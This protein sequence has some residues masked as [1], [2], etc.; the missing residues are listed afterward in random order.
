MAKKNPI[1]TAI[2][3]FSWFFLIIV[4]YYVIHK[5]INPQIAQ[6]FVLHIWR[7]ILCA[8]I[9]LIAGG[10]GVKINKFEK[11]DPP[12]KV[13][14]QA[15]LGLGVLS[16]TI[17]LIGS[18]WKINLIIASV[19]ILIFSIITYRQIINWIKDFVYSKQNIF[20][21]QNSSTRIIIAL[22]IVI[23][24]SQLLVSLTPAT[25]Y[26]ALNYHLSLPKTYLLQEKISDIPWLIMSGMPQI[27]EMIYTALLALGGESAVLVFN[28]FTG[29]LILSG[30]VGFLKKRTDNASAWVGAASLFGGY[31]F[32]SALS[33]GYVD[34]MTAFFGLG[35][36]VLVDEFILSGK[37]EYVFF[38][39]AFCGLAFGCKYPAGV[40]FIA[41]L[42]T[43]LVILIKN[44]HTK[45][46][47]KLAFFS[48]GAGLLALPWLL[49]NF[50][51]TGNPIYPFFFTAGS[52]TELRLN[53][54]QGM[55]PF[56]DLL[57]LFFLP[58]RATIIGLDGA[59]GYSV[60]TGPLMLALGLL[61]F[62]AWEEKT[63]DQ[64]RYLTVTGLISLFGILVWAI[65]N[66]IS[67]YLIQTRFYFVLFPVFA[68]L[69]AF[70]Y[71][72]IKNYKI[73]QVRLKRL[74]DFF[75]I[76]VLG[77]NSIQLIT[78]MVE[79]DVLSSVVGAISKQ[80]YLEINLGWYASAINKVNQ[81]EET[82]KV[83]FLY[84]PRGYSCI[85]VCD[86]DEILDH[87]KVV[88]HENKSEKEILSTWKKQG[89]T[90]VLV[91]T[92]GME[93]LREYEDPHHPVNELDSLIKLTTRLELVE[94]F[95]D[96]YKLYL[97]PE[98]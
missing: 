83:M 89:F 27:S 20:K 23:F 93:F 25:R 50:L 55:A 34:L 88:Y 60:S 16:L 29:V 18:I 58:I 84:E 92:K 69:S 80:Q 30:L 39:G 46:L 91:Y 94:N 96:W 12:Q 74:V 8:G 86:P 64:K 59:H 56:G 24:I 68:S 90:H 85:P 62:L 4:G 45:K 95:G 71:F 57:D 78:E 28:C 49:K 11:L 6:M 40:I 51:F 52:M 31:T 21:N 42:F 47:K 36:L 61:A 67:G 98:N 72:Q 10:I 41:G 37:N 32:A 2:I 13:F 66:Q 1:I 44:K 14:L 81:L 38:A 79:K 5:P 17:L 73:R 75:I 48:L 15:G 35:V 3:A 82:N 77:L 19:L 63:P 97:L 53:V 22:I 65:G 76:L 87:W 33:W 26:D 70:G 54:Y 43:L 7:I 9:I